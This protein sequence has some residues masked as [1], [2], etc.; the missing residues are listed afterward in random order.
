[1][2]HSFIQWATSEAGLYLHD[3]EQPTLATWQ[4]YQVD[5]LNHVFPMSETDERLPYNRIIWSDV[6]K[7]GKSELA[8]GVHQYFAYFVEVPGEQYVLSNDLQG[9]RG[10]VFRAIADGL[11]KNPHMKEG[12]DW[13]EVGNE[14]YLISNKSRT[15]IRAI[16]GDYRGEA[17]SNHSL[18]TVDE[19]WG[20]IHMGGERLMTEFSP[21]P[22]RLNS[23]IFYTG[24]QG[25]EGES[26]WWHALIDN[27]KVEPVPELEHI[28]NPDGKPCCWR[29]GRTF[30]FWNKVPRQ[31]WHTEEFLEGQRKAMKGQMNEYLRVWY[32]QR[33]QG[34]SAFC[35]P[36]QWDA[37]FDPNL[38][39]LHIGDTRRVVLGV[40]AATKSDCCALEAC[41]WNNE[42]KRVEQVFSR[43]WEPENGI[44]K[45]TETIGPEIVRLHREHKVAAVYFDPSQ[46]MAISELCQREKVNMVEFQQGTRRLESDKH[47]RDLIW[48]G[49]L[50][51]TGDPTLREH[52]TNALAKS[53]ERGLRIVKELGTKKVDGAVALAMAALGA[54]EVLVQPEYGA[55]GIPNPFYGEM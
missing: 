34:A 9:A 2:R 51:H 43:I 14:I 30:V 13:R 54:V 48:D 26:E 19:P 35:S 31:P 25:F 47:L 39:A 37:L 46:M 36:E 50:T 40:D 7:S 17:G 5:I 29:D 49:N 18:A 10:R 21:I 52:V 27:A 41:T 55:E 28:V 33:V 1:M 53:S 16:P 11:A 23:L 15:P 42:T 8:A 44:I 6:K 45:L 3:K 20:I 12:R 4:P 24:Y 22:T 32:N 38:R